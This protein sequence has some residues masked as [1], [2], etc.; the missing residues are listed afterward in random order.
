MITDL[1]IIG[2]GAVGLSLADCALREGLRVTVLDK[3]DMG[4]E[5]SWAGAGMLTCR[6]RPRR[7]PGEFDYHDL[8]IFS[9]QLHVQWAARLLEETGIDVG[10][11]VCGALELI[12][13]QESP[14][15]QQSA[16][17]EWIAACNERGVFA[18]LINSADARRLEPSLTVDFAQ[19]IEFPGEAQIRNPRF[20]RALLESI[21]KKGG[22]LREGAAVAD[23]HVE[24]GRCHGVI[25]QSGEKVPAAA[26]AVCAGAW[27]SQIP[28]L[29]QAVPGITKISPVR[30]QLLC[31]ETRPEIARRLL[32]LDNHY[33]VPRGDGVVLVGA[34][35]DHAGFDK[36]ITTEGTCELENFAHW[37]L[38]DL[39]QLKP[40]HM[41][42]GLR[43]GLK[44]R[45]PLLGP[46]S[47][48]TGLYVSA[49]HYRNGLNLAPASAELVL[50][51]IVGRKPKIP[52]ESWLPD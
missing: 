34:T 43:P 1:L 42:T 22:Q 23:L 45:H 7:T 28:V 49:G 44:G 16:I 38:P 13:T 40:V 26:V 19:A 37:L 17:H 41:W 8:K 50:A 46:V 52:V 31:Y 11:R 21:R 5:S 9:C 14:A 32:T 2:G 18:R 20:I 24:A 51:T 27:T 30:G 39:R 47:K 29:A 4:R 15:A 48:I 36:S 12:L 6:P 25:L 10:Y 35:H 3:G 33:A